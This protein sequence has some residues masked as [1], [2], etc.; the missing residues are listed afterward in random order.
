MKIIQPSFVINSPASRDEGVQMLRTIERFARVSHRSE[1]AQ[2]EDSWERFIRAVVL[3]K[4]DWSV[5]E[6]C[7]A[8]VTLRVDRGITH[9]IVRHRLFSYTQES[10]RF[11]NY[12]KRELEFI[13]PTWLLDAVKIGH[14]RYEWDAAVAYAESAYLALLNQN[15]PPQAARAVLPTCTA[16][17][18]VMTGNLRNWRYFFQART[19]RE[20]HPDMRRI[21]VPLLKEFQDKVPILFEDINPNDKQSIA[22]GKPR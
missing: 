5:T 2:T 9:E 11:V 7:S 8:S 14:P 18:L 19:S 4:G 16:A 3:Q 10:T 13:E 12:G 21:T 17:T 20:S 1:D 15:Q 22:F 6:H